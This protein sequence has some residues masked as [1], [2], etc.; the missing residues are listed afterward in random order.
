MADME[1]LA[2]TRITIL[3]SVSIILLAV[4]ARKKDT[5]IKSKIEGKLVENTMV[6]N[7]YRQYQER[8]RMR[9][10]E[11]QRNILIPWDEYS[12]GTRWL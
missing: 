9:Q 2:I 7:W 1:L 10:Q 3:N 4:N 12:K 5:E 11:A 6:H 8:Q